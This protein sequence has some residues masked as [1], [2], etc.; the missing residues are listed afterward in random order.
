MQPQ[1][2]SVP[3]ECVM[4][5]YRSVIHAMVI[6]PDDGEWRPMYAGARF[7]AACGRNMTEKETHFL[8]EWDEQSSLCQHPD[9]ARSGIRSTRPD[10]RYKPGE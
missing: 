10:L 9:A 6:A 7:R 8:S 2:P 1:L 3:D 5:K 4:G